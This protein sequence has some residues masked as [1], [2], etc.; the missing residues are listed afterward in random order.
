MLTNRM[1]ADRPSTYV[2]MLR[3]KQRRQHAALSGAQPA[4]SASFAPS[5][6]SCPADHTVS[7]H[8]KP[9]IGERCSLAARTDCAAD[10]R[11][12]TSATT[13]PKATAQAHKPGA[14]AHQARRASAEASAAARGPTQTATRSSRMG[15]GSAEV[16]AGRISAASANSAR[17]IA[18]KRRDAARGGNF[19]SAAAIDA[20]ESAVAAARRRVAATGIMAIES[21]MPPVPEPTHVVDGGGEAA[22]PACARSP[23][24][25]VTQ[26]RAVQTEAPPRTRPP[27]CPQCRAKEEQLAAK[28]AE[29]RG[30]LN[31][32]AR[33]DLAWREM[34]ALLEA[35]VSEAKG[36]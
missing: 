32:L 6:L 27:P 33:S 16:H 20:S 2:E 22:A 18:G 35:Q 3:G 4:L 17:V 8:H 31:E 12:C 19:R 15:A 13:H 21:R 10:Q 7:P 5:T 14:S 29:V 30:V 1:L 23:P 25:V 26:G 24:R 9:A 11:P 28:E 36:R 34:V